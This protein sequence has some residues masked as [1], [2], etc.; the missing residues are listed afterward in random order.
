MAII[1]LAGFAMLAIV[2]AI[3]TVMSVTVS[4]TER[5]E[6]K[7]L[8]SQPHYAV[9]DGKVYEKVNDSYIKVEDVISTT[10]KDVKQ[11]II[12]VSPGT[13][14]EFTD[15]WNPFKSTKVTDILLDEVTLPANS[16]PGQMITAK[17]I[18]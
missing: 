9:K 14:L 8:D 1:G 4:V 17:I 10:I 3:Q 12:K 7:T 16:Q 6:L 18:E 2:F 15:K 13:V 5:P 11:P